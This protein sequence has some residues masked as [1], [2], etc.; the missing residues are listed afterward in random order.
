[1]QPIGNLIAKL[2][3]IVFPGMALMFYVAAKDQATRQFVGKY[4]LLNVIVWSLTLF[5]TII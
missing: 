2:W 3:L 5:F 1:M 4:L